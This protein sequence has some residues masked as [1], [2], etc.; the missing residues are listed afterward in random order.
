MRLLV[1]LIDDVLAKFPAVACI[2]SL[3]NLTALVGCDID[4]L[5]ELARLDAAAAKLLRGECTWLDP[6]TGPANLTSTLRLLVPNVKILSID[7]RGEKVS[8]L[9]KES[10]LLRR[11]SPLLTRDTAGTGRSGFDV[12]RLTCELVRRDKVTSTA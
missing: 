11:S 5:L 12:D 9:G 7:T 3:L 2:M 1:E 10:E 4:R 6:N 8:L